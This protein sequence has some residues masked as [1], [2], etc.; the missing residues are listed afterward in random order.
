[1]VSC[2]YSLILILFKNWNNTKLA[3][4]GLQYVLTKS[5]SWFLS[6]NHEV[7]VSFNWVSQGLSPKNSFQDTAVVYRKLM[8]EVLMLEWCFLHWML[9]RKN[10]HRSTIALKTW[11][12]LTSL[13]RERGLN[14]DY[15][16]NLIIFH[17]RKRS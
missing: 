6:L 11:P 5:G 1:M 12:L 4:I 8:I 2:I 10:D 15:W 16:Q 3:C 17:N 13:N 7:C 9:R 14:V